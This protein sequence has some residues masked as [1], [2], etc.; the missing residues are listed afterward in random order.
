MTDTD[1]PDLKEATD[2]QSNSAIGAFA[3]LPLLIHLHMETQPMR[4]SYAHDKSLF[5]VGTH[6]VMRDTRQIVVRH[7]ITCIRKGSRL[8]RYKT[9]HLPHQA[10]EKLEGCGEQL[11]TDQLTTITSQ[12]FAHD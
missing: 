1:L 11:T 12:Q 9:F 3:F 6:E 2:H 7:P 4:Y 10:I 8:D 5:P